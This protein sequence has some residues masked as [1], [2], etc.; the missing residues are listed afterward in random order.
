MRFLPAILIA[1][2]IIMVPVVWIVLP[3]LLSEAPVDSFGG[4]AVD[5]GARIE[6]E[7]LRQQ[8]EAM[9]ERMTALEQRPPAPS[10]SAIPPVSLGSP[11]EEIL[12]GDGVN[13]IIDAYAQ[14]VLIANRRNVNK[15]ISV[16]GPRF[17]EQTLGRPREELGDTCEPMTNPTLKGKLVVADVG[18]IKVRMLDPAVDSLRRVFENVRDSDPDLHDRISTA[19]S[20]CVRR[21]RGSRNALSSHSFG[22]AVDLNIDGHLDTLGDGYTQLGL[23]ILADFFRSEGWIWGAG[24]SRE[25]SMHFEVSQE[26]VLKWRTEGKL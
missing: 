24:F 22:L 21:I 8:I 3:K 4:P 20:L 5:S 12:P 6:I 10:P 18:P 25:D 17:L 15:G 11:Q 13:S 16:A 9:Q 19:G 7:N 2:A 14:V 1:V 26:Q 23:T